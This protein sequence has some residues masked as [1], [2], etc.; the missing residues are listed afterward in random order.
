M[1][2]TFFYLFLRLLC[3]IDAHL[4]SVPQKSSETKSQIET[5]SYKTPDSGISLISTRLIR[6]KKRAPAVLEAALHNASLSNHEIVSTAEPA[7]TAESASP[8]EPIE[9]TKVTEAK[10]DANESA[11]C[12]D[13][14]EKVLGAHDSSHPM[15]DEEDDNTLEAT[16]DW[17]AIARPEQ[18]EPEGDWRLW[19][20]L[21]GRGFGKTRTGAETVRAWVES[22]RYKRIGLVGATEA[23]IRHVMVEGCSGLLSVYP[24]DEAPRYEPSKRRIVWP[25]G[26]VA[27]LVSAERYE[28][29]RGLQ[30]DAIWIDELAK[31]RYPQET[32]DQVCLSLRLGQRPRVI[33]TT[34]PKATALI[35]RLAE[36]QSWSVVTR[37]STYANRANLAPGFIEHIEQSCQNEKLMRQEI[38]GEIV[39]DVVGALWRHEMLDHQRIHPSQVPEMVRVVVAVDPSVAHHEEGDETGIVV[40]GLGVDQKA[41]VLADLSG[42][43]GTPGWAEQVL[44]AY[45]TFEADC[46]IAEENQGGALVEQVLRAIDPDVFYQKVH[47]SRG[48]IARAE[49]V[50]TLY[51]RGRVHHVGQNLKQ[52]E[53]QLCTYVPGV[54]TVSPDR[55]DALVWAISSLLLSQNRPKRARLWTID[56]PSHFGV[57]EQ[58]ASALEGVGHIG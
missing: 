12:H 11:R 42:R 40:A 7:S 13:R 19:L 24:H 30:F 39:D 25:N 9:V 2:M 41:Y 34:T 45:V 5:L 31:F 37:G 46:I 38:Q 49:P 54:S 57:I 26:A 22:G 43:Y 3:W 35:K 6:T 44:N 56:K 10:A 55:L 47:A 8:T 36:Q 21:A 1:M 58:A 27:Y 23:D 18:R 32:W 4:A 14:S 51:T 52:L 53:N 50:S 16:Y 17:A 33:A 20:I 48:K 28:K 15:L 29:L